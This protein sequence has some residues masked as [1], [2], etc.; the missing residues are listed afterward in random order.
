MA[1]IFISYST[2]DREQARLLAAF[3]QADGYSVWWDTSL[4]SG[5][6]F[7]KVI[8]TELGQARAAIVIWTENST[9]SD[10]VQSEAGRAHADAKL[11]PVKAKGLSYKDIPPPFDNM[12]IENVDDREK[13]SA[14]LV[15]LLA[16]PQLQASGIARFSKRLRFEFLSW[17]GIA[18]AVITLTTNLQGMLTL[19]KWVRHFFESWIF[20]IKFV[21]SKLLFFLPQVPASDAI[22]LTFGSFAA[23]TMITCLEK[24]HNEETTFRRKGSIFVAATIIIGVFTAGIFL[25]IGDGRGE[26]YHDRF[27]DFQKSVPYGRLPVLFLFLLFISGLIYNPFNKPSLSR[28]LRW[29]LLGIG[30]SIALVELRQLKKFLN[31]IVGGHKSDSVV[32]ILFRILDIIVDV[33]NLIPQFLVTFF[34][35]FFPVLVLYLIIRFLSS[36]RLNPAAVSVRL[37]RIV[38]GVFIVI[39]LNYASL[40]VEQQGWFAQLAK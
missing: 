36:Y 7:R 11:I 3:L 8:M 29:M 9:A 34:I 2:E 6:N 19:A 37:W 31:D 25:A 1:D 17:F 4:L 39:G 27:I 26:S 5:D 18:G 32:D 35:P 22:L 16:K 24:N 28:V 38:G 13:I 30:L 15:A 23:I 21:W 20:V 40:W 10:W 14:A 33:L 12:H